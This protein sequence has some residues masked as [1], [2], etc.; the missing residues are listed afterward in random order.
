VGLG[1]AW[2]LSRVLIE[3]QVDNQFYHFIVNNWIGHSG[4]LSP[5]LTI[6]ESSKNVNVIVMEGRGLSGH[7]ELDRLYW[8]GPSASPFCTL[9]YGEHFGKTSVVTHSTNP[10]W[11]ESLFSF[12][13]VENS[14]L[15]IKAWDQGHEIGAITVNLPEKGIQDKWLLLRKVDRGTI[16]ATTTKVHELDTEETRWHQALEFGEL[17]VNLRKLGLNEYAIQD[18]MSVVKKKATRPMLHVRVYNQT[19]LPWITDEGRIFYDEEIAN[20]MKT[21]DVIAFSGES[22]LGATIQSKLNNP[23]SHV[24]LILKMQDAEFSDKQGRIGNNPGEKLFVLES[25]EYDSEKDWVQPS[26]SNPIVDYFEG[27]AMD[28]V[29]LFL[30]HDRIRNIDSR[31]IWH[32]PLIEPLHSAQREKLID[33]C[34]QVYQARLRFDYRQM[35]TLGVPGHENKQDLTAVF[36]S[37]LVS[38]LLKKIDLLPEGYNPSQV[39]PGDVINLACYQGMYPKLLQHICSKFPNYNLPIRLNLDFL[40]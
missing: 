17:I 28:G 8:I 25:H 9:D 7:E 10:V 6:N 20:E 23:V 4:T 33:A 13:P 3:D 2:F 39:T 26:G 35:V 37:E 16:K 27:K 24:G 18:I 31:A 19:A 14:S 29:N 34:R 11:N 5:Y 30:L 15:F 32:I 22:N 1:E 40:K 36:C 38:S 21:G 12:N